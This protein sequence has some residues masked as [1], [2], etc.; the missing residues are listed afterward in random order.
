MKLDFDIRE[1]DE[2]NHVVLLAPAAV[3]ILHAARRLTGRGPLAF[4]SVRSSHAIGPVEIE[5]ADLDPQMMLGVIGMLDQLAIQQTP[6][7]R[8]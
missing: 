8:W 5:T 4:C 7:D 6:S 3:Q 1:D 2:L